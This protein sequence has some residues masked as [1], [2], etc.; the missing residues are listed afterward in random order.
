MRRLRW[1]ADRAWAVSALLKP[2]ALSMSS[3]VAFAVDPLASF[4]F[5]GWLIAVPGWRMR[6]AVTETAPSSQEWGA[7]RLYMN[8]VTRFS[9]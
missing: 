4:R 9:L 5:F 1:N 8:D 2:R 7:R 3:T 6:R